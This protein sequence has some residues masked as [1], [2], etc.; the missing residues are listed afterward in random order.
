M[1][2][3]GRRVRVIVADDHPMV[4]AGVTRSLTLSGRIDVVGEAANGRTAL[5]AIVDERPDVALL[6]YRMP[7]LDGATVAA[8]VRRDG[9]PTRVLLLSAHTD[10]PIV[11]HALQQGAHGFLTKDADGPEIVNA[12]LDCAA[13][14]T[15]LAA[16]P[17]AG[18]FRLNTVM[19]APYPTASATSSVRRRPSSRITGS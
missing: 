19:P 15:V 8:A 1:R 3:G 14:R 2:D 4:R 6:D 7:D 13:G 11:F 16:A 10:P 17:S 9:L 12:V 18:R 5:A